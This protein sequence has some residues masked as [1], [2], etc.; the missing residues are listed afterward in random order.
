MARRF[1]TL[2]ARCLLGNH[3]AAMLEFLEDPARSAWLSYGGMATLASYGV[4]M[5]AGP[6]GDRGILAARGW[7]KCPASTLNS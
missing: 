7:R 6:I 3:E 4:S 2:P 1:A 5:P